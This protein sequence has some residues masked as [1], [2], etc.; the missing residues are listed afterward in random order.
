MHAVRALQWRCFSRDCNGNR[1]FVLMDE[2]R[3]YQYKFFSLL[4]AVKRDGSR[5]LPFYRIWGVLTKPFV[6]ND[7]DLFRDLH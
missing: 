4:I 1:F 3:H 6:R 2:P 7:R 5:L